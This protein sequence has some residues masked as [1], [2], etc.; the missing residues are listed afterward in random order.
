M[1]EPETFLCQPVRSLQTMLRVLQKQDDSYAEVI[2]DGIYGPQTTRAVSQFQKMHG[3]PVTG[4]TDQ[5]TWDT[6]VPH[7]ELAQTEV[8]PAE[9]LELSL[10]ANQVLS[11]NDENPLVYILQ[12]VLCVLARAY[13]CMGTPQQSGKMDVATVD[14][15]SSFQT[16]C[17]MPPTGQLDKKTWKQLAMH[18]PLAANIMTQNIQNPNENSTSIHNPFL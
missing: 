17:G 11:Q 8:N 7:F 10:N 9:P 6:I 12:A 18:Y 16:L 2:P 13:S 3:L 5:T 14:A 15:L 4:V 1:R